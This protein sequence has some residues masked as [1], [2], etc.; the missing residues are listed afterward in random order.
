ML[1]L[2]SQTVNH[3]RI[4]SKKY[5]TKGYAGVTYR[6][7]LFVKARPFSNAQKKEAERLCQETLDTGRF[8]ILLKECKLEQYT[9]CYQIPSAASPQS[10]RRVGKVLPPLP[11]PKQRFQD[12]SN[13]NRT[14][15]QQPK[16]LNMP[17][18]PASRRNTPPQYA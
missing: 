16:D 5:P 14:I 15:L 3:C 4:Y 9:L 18:A 13:D 12:S 11:L 7:L 1:I 8:C 6:D 17:P 2:D 10:A